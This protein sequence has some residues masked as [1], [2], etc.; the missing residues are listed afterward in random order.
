[1]IR[2]EDDEEDEED[3]DES[4][5]DLEDEDG[6]DEDDEEGSDEDA[7]DEDDSSDDDQDDVDEKADKVWK[8]TGTYKVDDKNVKAPDAKTKQQAIGKA[9]A[10]AGVTK[11]AKKLPNVEV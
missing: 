5:E 7:S 11:A 3:G 10:E 6:S 1:M 2:G 4:D 9:T 8:A